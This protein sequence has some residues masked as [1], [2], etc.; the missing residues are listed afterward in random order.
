MKGLV[1]VTLSDV[2][3]HL[4]FELEEELICMRDDILVLY[5]LHNKS[6]LA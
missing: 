5:C 1:L 3:V 4:F 2:C 6:P